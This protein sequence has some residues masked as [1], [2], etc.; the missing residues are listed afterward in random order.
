MGM[1]EC[2]R[3]YEYVRADN[4]GSEERKCKFQIKTLFPLRLYIYL[5]TALCAC[6]GVYVCPADDRFS[7]RF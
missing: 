4:K 1:C 7:A 5:V 6:G 3:A 2:V